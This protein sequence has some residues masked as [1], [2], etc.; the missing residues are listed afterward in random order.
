MAE[1]IPLGK[2]ENLHQEFKGREALKRP[3][4]IA[5]EVVAMLNAQGGVVWV[6]LRA[7][8]DRAVQVEPVLRAERERRRLRDYLVDTIEPSPAGDEV[9]VD[10]VAA[11]R[12][13]ILHIEARP[14]PDRLPL[15][16]LWRG[17]ARAAG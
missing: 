12:G 7:E 13:E 1:K 11:D 5:R 14:K 2:K 8:C 3:D 16:L 9:A 10:V 6:G 15:L 4:V 17:A